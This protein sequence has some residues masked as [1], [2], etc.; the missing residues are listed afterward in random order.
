MSFNAKELWKN[1]EFRAKAISAMNS[2]EANSKK[3]LKK[4][5][6]PGWGKKHSTE[7]KRK[8]SATLTSTILSGKFIPHASHMNGTLLHEKFLGGKIFYRSSYEKIFLEKCIEDDEVVTVESAPFM[9]PYSGHR[10]YLPDF[11][12]NGKRLIE[13]KPFRRIEEENN[14]IKFEAAKIFCDNLGITFEIF[15]EKNF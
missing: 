4:E 11:L 12:V 15:T 13:V 3:G 5:M 7:R 2:E 1:E 10:H 9:I 6:H 14:R 8:Q